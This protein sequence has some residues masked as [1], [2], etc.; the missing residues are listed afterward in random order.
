[1]KTKIFRLG[2]KLYKVAPSIYSPLYKLYKNVTDKNEIQ[3]LGKVLLPGMVV[4]DIGANIGLYS[5]RF[6]KIVG[7]S[8][9]IF[10]FEPDRTN[11]NLLQK[12]TRNYSNIVNVNSAV[13]SISGISQLF[14]STDLNV[15]HQMYDDGN[16]R[17]SID[18]GM[19][20]LDDY[21]YKKINLDFIKSDTQGFEFEV[22]KGGQ[23][24]LKEANAPKILFEYW[25]FGLINAGAK[26][27]DLISLLKDYGYKLEIISGVDINVD[28][29][30]LPVS[31]DI[32]LNLLA[33][34]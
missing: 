16:G 20:S 4:A 33:H 19:T 5:E 8:G 12:R 32:Y 2:N 11:F 10:A 31:K 29:I 3:L 27:S 34:K 14:L 17:R 30:N 13:G 15:D 1:M 18:V 28:L 22:F 25:P 26:P 7:E 23:N 9:R 6:S 21:F 24:L